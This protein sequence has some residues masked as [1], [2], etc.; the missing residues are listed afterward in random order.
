M[1]TLVLY[2]F[3]LQRALSLTFHLSTLM[4]S[5][6]N[7]S[8]LFTAYLQLFDWSSSSSVF[9]SRSSFL[10]HHLFPFFFFVFRW[11]N[12][13][14]SGRG[15]PGLSDV[16]AFPFLPLVCG[17]AC[18]SPPML[19]T[20]FLPDTHSVTL[21]PTSCPLTAL[22]LQSEPPVSALAAPVFTHFPPFSSP[23]FSFCHFSSFHLPDS[24]LPWSFTLSLLQLDLGATEQ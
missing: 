6:E 13:S 24:C 4:P 10:F 9:F 3:V 15:R 8:K 1:E 18:L 22:L 14:L 12:V 11:Q 19:S 2:V 20:H 23:C 21:P 16:S 7:H 17:C 5:G